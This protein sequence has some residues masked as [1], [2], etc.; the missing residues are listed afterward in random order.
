MSS[1]LWDYKATLVR[2]V[3]VVPGISS[4]DN[5][6]GYLTLVVML[7]TNTGH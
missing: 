6:G 7:V 2:A 4:V 3:S 1:Y 5:T